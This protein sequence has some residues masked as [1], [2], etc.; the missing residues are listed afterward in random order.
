MKTLYND[1]SKH[2]V[3]Y[4]NKE[5]SDIL[6]DAKMFIVD[7]EIVKEG[8]VADMGMEQKLGEV[9]RE[10]LNLPFPK[11]LIYAKEQMY[12]FKEVSEDAIEFTT[13]VRSS[14]RHNVMFCFSGIMN[15]D[16]TNLSSR[17]AN[18]YYVSDGKMLGRKLAMSDKELEPVLKSLMICAY[19]VIVDLNT[20]DRFIVKSTPIK[21][22]PSK[23]YPRFREL[24]EYILLKPKEIREKLNLEPLDGNVK[25]VHERRGHIRTY[26]DDKSKYPKAHGKHVWIKACWVGTSEATVGN[27]HYKVLL[28]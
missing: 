14:G 3:R 28:D 22:K 21:S 20:V 15:I 7:F 27:R 23:D 10:Q 17:I 19:R 13:V 16:G 24:S 18:S 6:R 25:R 1:F 11:T 9:K 5:K 26:P 12:L 8:A 4:K 2:L